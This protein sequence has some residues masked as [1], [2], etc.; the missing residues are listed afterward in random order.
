MPPANPENVE[1]RIA[2]HLRNA[3]RGEFSLQVAFGVA[4]DYAAEVV[5]I[6]GPER[7]SEIGE[8]EHTNLVLLAIHRELSL[9]E[10]Q[11][12]KHLTGVYRARRI[13]GGRWWQFWS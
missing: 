7:A 12:T 9:P 2:E 8:Q 6:L 11:R 10:E 5:K 1:A 3:L 4:K 13:W